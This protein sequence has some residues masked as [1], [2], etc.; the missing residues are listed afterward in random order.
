MGKMARRVQIQF[1]VLTLLLAAAATAQLNPSNLLVSYSFDDGDLATGPDTFSIFAHAKGTVTLSS[2]SH[3][4]GYRSVEIRDVASDGDFPELQGYFHPRDKGRLFLHFALMTATPFEELNIALAGP[5]WFRL[6]KNGIGFWLKTLKGYLYQVSDSMPKKLFLLEPFVWY[7]VNVAYD[8]DHGAYDLVIHKEGQPRPVVSLTRQV[9]APNQPGSA[10]DKFSFI[11][12]KG[13]DTSNVAYYVDDVIVGID[14]AIIQL[15]FVAPGRRKLFIDYWSESQRRLHSKPEPLEVMELSDLGI[16]SREIQSLRREGLWDLLLQLISSKKQRSVIPDDVSTESSQLLHA[17]GFWRESC[18]A[19][20]KGETTAALAGFEKA[21][22]LVPSGKIYGMD[23]VLALA[24]LGQWQAVDARLARVYSDWQGDLRL[25]V[26]LAKVGLAQQNLD[27][28]EQ[29]LRGPAEQVPDE[30]GRGLL[31][32]LRSG[33]INE[34]MLEA[35]RS[36]FP[37]KGADY[38]RDV[39]IAEEY[40]FVLLWKNRASEAEQFAERMT[41]RYQRLDIPNS[42]W[43]ER[44]GDASFLMGNFSGAL[45][46]YEES[47]KEDPRN[48][49]ILVKLS[50]VHFRLGDLER[51]RFYR[52]KI[53]GRLSQD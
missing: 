24:A 42:K 43:L 12:D 35:L 37:D 29:W 36:R 39:L 51:E 1:I 13:E 9:N 34:T 32:R 4:S 38:V 33:E 8:I 17:V 5:E 7:V 11:G 14:E 6:R 30:I 28:A 20:K 49:G 48:T 53:Y 45:E 27:E 3:L 31:R 19:M 40:F 23:A 22:Q 16:R 25:P 41:A 10:V 46:R 21:D 47:L 15:P 2:A 18:E 44:L 50:D 26:A 52:E